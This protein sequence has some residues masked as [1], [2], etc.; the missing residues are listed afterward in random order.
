MT[1]RRGDVRRAAG[2]HPAP[3]RAMLPCLWLAAGL[4]LLPGPARAELG[5]ATT[6]RKWCEKQTLRYLRKHGYEP[7]NWTATTYI[8]GSD[9]VTKGTWRID[10]D[11]LE[12]ECVSSKRR[13]AG[14]RYKIH[15]IDLPEGG[16]PGAD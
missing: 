3:A 9:Y 7:Y 6:A 5:P 15:G 14:G 2:R 10:V 4:L 8:E 12:V 1:T 13:G 11:E 16:R